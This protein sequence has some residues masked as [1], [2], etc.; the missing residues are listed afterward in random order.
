MRLL[1]LTLA[2]T[3]TVVQIFLNELNRFPF[4]A[5]SRPLVSQRSLMALRRRDVA[6]MPQWRFCREALEAPLLKKLEGRSDFPG[7]TACRLTLSPSYLILQG[8]A[9]SRRDS[10]VRLRDEVHGRSAV[11]TKQTGHRSHRQHFQAGHCA[12]ESFSDDAPVCARGISSR[13]TCI[14]CCRR[15]SAMSSTVNCFVS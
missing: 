11:A 6:P 10:D 7:K 4:R 2:P 3:F 8:R 15:S 13:E 14:L 9:V 1:P 12:R 5:P